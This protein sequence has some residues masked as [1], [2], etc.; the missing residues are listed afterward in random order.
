MFR[1][2]AKAT[3][4]ALLAVGLATSTSSASTRQCEDNAK[5]ELYLT[6]PVDRM[7]PAAIADNYL[8]EK[9]LPK[10]DDS[11]RR[12]WQEFGTSNESV[13][14]LVENWNA[15]RVAKNA[16]AD[17]EEFIE[18]L[19]QVRATIFAF[20]DARETPEHAAEILA[21]KWDDWR[22]EHMSR[23][24]F[25]QQYLAEV[26]DRR[27]DSVPVYGAILH[28][29]Q[30][31]LNRLDDLHGAAGLRTSPEDL[32]QMWSWDS[33]L[34]GKSASVQVDTLRTMRDGMAYWNDYLIG[35]RT[36][37]RCLGARLDNS[38][39]PHADPSTVSE[40]IANLLFPTEGYTNPKFFRAIYEGRTEEMRV[41][42]V[43]LYLTTFL[44]MFT[45]AKDAP[46]CRNVVSQT[47]LFR[48]A[49]GGSQDVLGR[50]FGGLAQAHRNRGGNRD[51]L[52]GQGFDAGTGTFGGMILSE[53]SAEADA[54]LFYS[55][56]GCDTPVATRF[57][58]NI[59]DFAV[60]N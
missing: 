23:E 46:E 39:S 18:T 34:R 49:G 7:T 36:T 15:S 10:A 27:K 32:Y 41:S 35:R 55:R 38:G 26:S 57:F 11:L 37:I 22:A 4:A 9:V 24:E 8:D 40:T 52:F 48:I 17:R 59:S 56:H 53:A 42:Q 44:S 47:T 19:R 58:G 51:D 60:Q 14:S 1:T 31:L 50:I 43:G 13:T 16:V 5:A 21:G 54:Q 3:L 12:F 29:A 30:A 20:E 6:Q 25:I 45:N 33:Y 2:T 28:A